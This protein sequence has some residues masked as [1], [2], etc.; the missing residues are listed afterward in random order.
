MLMLMLI[1]P[2]VMRLI[3]INDHHGAD[4]DEEEDEEDDS[5]S[6]GMPQSAQR[7]RG[8]VIKCHLRLQGLMSVA[9]ADFTHE[10]TNWH[11]KA[12]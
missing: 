8:F 2:Q 11:K 12:S 3:I 9:K 5:F 10:K 7:P 1:M 6:L 4:D